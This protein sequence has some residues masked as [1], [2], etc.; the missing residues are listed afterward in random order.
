M[1]ETPVLPAFIF[2]T[3]LARDLEPHV[4]LQHVSQHMKWRRSW[5][6]RDPRKDRKHHHRTGN[7][8]GT[9]NGSHKRQLWQPQDLLLA[10]ATTGTGTG[11]AFRS[12]CL[13]LLVQLPTVAVREHHQ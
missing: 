6:S 12:Q 2:R 11:T 5:V 3:V 13:V 9:G 10:D 4:Q 7:S 1:S 8:A